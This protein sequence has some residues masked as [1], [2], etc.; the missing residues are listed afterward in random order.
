MSDNDLAQIAYEL[1]KDIK[2]RL[3]RAQRDGNPGSDGEAPGTQGQGKLI[4]DIN[5]K[6]ESD[7]WIIWDSKRTD[8]DKYV[9]NCRQWKDGELYQSIKKHLKRN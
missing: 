6:I 3:V 7:T 9:L 5:S 8:D 2:N 4:L 1:S